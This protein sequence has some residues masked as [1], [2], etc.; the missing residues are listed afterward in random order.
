VP[1]DGELPLADPVELGLIKS[2]AEA[3]TVR[4]IFDR[5]LALGCV[6]KLKVDLDQKGIRSKQ[7]IL[8]RERSANKA[9]RTGT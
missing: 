2:A 3:E 4:L 6:S 9:A 1:K 7:R 5:Y 8:S